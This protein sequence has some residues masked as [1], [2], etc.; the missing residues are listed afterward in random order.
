MSSWNVVQKSAQSIQC[1]ILGSMLFDMQLCFAPYT[2]TVSCR[3]VGPGLTV[4]TA[5]GCR[6]L[7]DRVPSYPKRPRKTSR[8]AGPDCRCRTNH[9]LCNHSATC[10]ALLATARIRS[11]RQRA[12]SRHQ[13]HSSRLQRGLHI[14][15][16]VPGS[17]WELR[18]GEAVSLSWCGTPV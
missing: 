8:W 4:N 16:L 1:T 18:A 6:P 3:R 2:E 12:T 11:I 15:Y 17:H 10:L 9:L 14:A 5:D 7:I 13:L